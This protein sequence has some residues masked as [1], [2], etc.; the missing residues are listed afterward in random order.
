MVEEP[1][2]LKNNFQVVRALSVDEAYKQLGEHDVDLLLVNQPLA[3]GTHNLVGLESL[4][5]KQEM[6]MVFLVD[7]SEQQLQDW[8]ETIPVHGVILKGSPP[9][10]HVAILKNALKIFAEKQTKKNDPEKSLK[11]ASDTKYLAK[12]NSLLQSIYRINQLL[13]SYSTDQEVMDE[14]CSTL[15]ADGNFEMAWIG[16]VNAETMQVEPKAIAGDNYNYVRSIQVYADDRPEGRGPIGIAIRTNKSVVVQDAMNDPR[17]TVWSTQRKKTSW[18]ASIAVPFKMRHHANAILVAYSNEVNFF[19]ETE[20]SMLETIASNF[21]LAIER[22]AAE[23]EIKNQLNQ[24]TALLKEVHHRTKNNIVAIESL[25]FLQL[26][27]CTDEPAAEILQD[28]INRV[29]SMRA[30][31]DHLLMSDDFKNISVREYV[32]SL[33]DKVSLFIIDPV[34][35]KINHRIDEF[36]LDSKRVFSIGIIVNELLTNAAKYAFNSGEFGEIDIHII[37]QSDKV[38]LSVNDNGVGMP[39]NFSIEKSNGFGLMLVKMLTQEL[40]G[41]LDIDGNDGVPGTKVSVTFSLGE[42]KFGS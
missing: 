6:P 38:L 30:L 17:L 15:V 8:I 33:I 42:C 35:I 23:E 37:Q 22:I 3:D 1:L 14:I 27:K 5:S 16:V 21:Q 28:A 9:W 24:K 4:L 19:E 25:L 39:E 26:Q 29:K 2:L 31:Y 34:R 32:L 10:L 7:E 13:V 18:N 36:N 41:E 20:I 12:S 40:K 11:P